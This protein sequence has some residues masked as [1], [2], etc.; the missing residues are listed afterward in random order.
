MIY[1][2]GNPTNLVCRP[3]TLERSQ[4]WD[5]FVRSQSGGT[6]F[7]LLAWQRTI[8]RVFGHE[9]FYLMAEDARNG[10]LRGVLPLFLVRSRIFGKMLISTPQAVYGGILAQV[11]EAERLLLEKAREI[12]HKEGAKFVE[13]RQFASGI[14]DPSLATRDL[15]VTFRQQIFSD[16]EKNM[17]AIPRKTRAEIREG[18]RND[19]EFKVDSISTAEFYAIYARSVRELGTPVFPI[20]LFSIG[21]EEFGGQH[22][23]IFSVHWRGRAVAAVWTLFYKQEVLPYYGGSLREFNRLAVNN[24]MYWMLIKYGCDSGYQTYDF[25]RSKKGSGSYNFKKR[26]GM[27]EIDLPYQYALIK[28]KTMPD[29]S[30][31][32]PKFSLGIRVWRRLPLFVTNA[33]GPLISRHLT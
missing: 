22:C 20:R 26:W 28:Q 9:P 8:C 11:P 27:V 15:Y 4:Q 21:R 14:A 12:G 13:F 1:A 17:Q 23:K 29:M 32:N 16:S 3:L 30:P 18:I 24:F 10:D 19:L 31:L 25:G 33:I 6:A 7:H 2:Q 5:D